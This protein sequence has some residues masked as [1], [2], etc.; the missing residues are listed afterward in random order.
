MNIINNKNIFTL[1]IFIVIGIFGFFSYH[2]FLS[3]TDYQAKVNSG[4][5]RKYID[6]ID[7]LIDK[8]LMERAYSAVYMASEGREGYSQVEKARSEVDLSIAKLKE[9][10]AGSKPSVSYSSEIESVAKALKHVR[11]KVDT[12]SAD[13]KNVLFNIYHNEV[14]A[15][16]ITNEKSI[17][18][19][20][21][22]SGMEEY[23]SLYLKFTELKENI[24]LEKIGIHFILNGSR[25]MSNKDLILWDN[26]LLNDMLPD[27]NAI[28]ERSVINKLNA[29]M[30]PEEYHRL[31]SK[32]RVK[33]FYGSQTGEYRVT[34][35]EWSE[36]M[37]KKLNYTTVAQDILTAS[38][39]KR[40]QS[41]LAEGKDIMARYG[42][43]VLFTFAILL[44]MLL[45]Y[46]NINKDK[47]LFEDTLK[48]IET[49]LSTEQQKRLKALIDNRKTNEIYRF[50]TQTIRDANQAKDLFLANMSHEIRTPLN[51]IVGFTQLLKGTPL[52]EEQKEFINVIENSSDNLLTIVNDILDLSKIKADKVELEH[53]PFDPVEKFESSVESYAA[54]AAEKDIEFGIYMDPSL[55]GRLVGDPTK[56]SQVVVNLISNAI[57]FTPQNGTVA[58]RIEKLAETDTTVT[59]RFSVE[60]S[61]I[62][63]SEEQRQNIFDAFTQADV[64]TNRKYGGTGL[65]LAISG[66]FVS[67]MGGKLDIESEEEEGTAFFFTLILEKPSEI[68]E[69]KLLDTSGHKVGFV[70]SGEST[71]FV[72]RKNIEAYITAAGA[73]FKTYYG[74]EI[75]NE[76]RSEIPDILFLDHQYIQTKEE[77]EKYLDLDAKIVL[78]TTAEKKKLIEDLQG[79]IDRVFY[80][81]VSL[82]KTLKSLDVISEQEQQHRSSTVQDIEGE[83]V[84][85][86][87]LHVLVAED[88][89][90]NQKLILNILNGFGIDVTLA[91]NGEEAVNL[92]REKGYDLVFMDIQMPVLGGMEATAEILA[93]EKK[94]HR[95]HTPIIALT[96]N[97]LKGD[98]DKYMKAGM[99]NY[100]SKPLDLIQV[101]TLIQEYFPE[102]IIQKNAEE[103]TD[104]DMILPGKS[105]DTLGESD[106][107]G[108]SSEETA[109]ISIEEE[110]VSNISESATA[111]NEQDN[112]LVHTSRGK[113]VDILLYRSIP[114]VADLYERILK[115]L[116]YSVEKV[117]DENLLLDKLEEGARYSFVLYDVK[118]FENM[119]CLIG[120]I[121]RNEGAIPVAFVP[122]NLKE[123]EWCSEQM[124]AMNA[125]P[126]DIQEA[127]EQNQ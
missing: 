91:K 23:L 64:S 25:K 100:L 41:N 79:D 107:T 105:D 60:D 11:T 93:L 46:Y 89:I 30:T 111:A 40:M 51:G 94:N 109:E 101:N 123:K 121:I 24:S 19:D 112:S 73:A 2:T 78:L 65:G 106:E 39:K 50:L 69:R 66:K 74:D 8:V 115:N 98:K 48:D 22:F 72:T 108:K 88:N 114:L 5:S 13:Y 3:Y 67:I 113:Q 95:D 58:T 21:T 43:A 102:K 18:A 97:A 120:D 1:L 63:I 103:Q 15:P 76:E 80:K 52:N 125:G 33:V 81:P 85:F 90:I 56:V 68:E 83:I 4:K 122:E 26:L 20:D 61:G 96:A 29:L 70:T 126:K 42:S 99:D 9:Y 116:N 31:G 82:S 49:V 6:S 28:K 10:T 16:L 117:T 59:V 53:I 118:P 77:I 62:G 34:T 110:K 124:I 47:Q 75:F 44:I 54:K 14:I 119:P 32:E 36:K 37:D 55:P 38:M 92:C 12:L 35:E 127:L 57:K 27:I 45:V 84:Q 87:K 86:E 71:E 104:E 17:I 7:K